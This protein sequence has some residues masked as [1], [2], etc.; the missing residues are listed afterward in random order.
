[1][2]TSF[3]KQWHYVASLAAF[4][5]GVTLTGTYHAWQD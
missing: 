4:C 2:K 5:V 3:R 1:M